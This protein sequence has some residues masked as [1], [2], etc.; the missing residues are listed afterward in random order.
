[1]IRFLIVVSYLIISI[2][3]A[4]Q[5]IQ[6]MDG[7]KWQ[8]DLD[9]LAKELPKRHKNLYHQV[10][11]EKFQRAI[12]NLKQN[13]PTLSNHEIAVEFARIVAM[14]G[15]GHTELSLIQSATQF[16]RIPLYFYYFGDSLYIIAATEIYK[17]TIG[18]R[19]LKI[20]KSSVE[21]SFEAVKALISHD[22][23]MEYRH[24]GPRYLAVPKI[25]HALKL[26]ENM[27]YEN[28]VV[29]ATSG[30]ID[31]IRVKAFE[32]GQTQDWQTALA[33]SGN[34]KPLFLQ[35]QGNNYWFTFLD[36]TKTL[37]LNYNRCQNQN[38][39][40][41]IKEF[42]KE[43]FNFVDNNTIDRFIFDLRDNSGGNMKLNRPLIEG[44]IE[45][46]SINLKGNLF[47]ITGRRT[48]SAGTKA[49]IE[50]K[51]NTEAIFVG[52]PSRGKPNGYGE[53]EKFRLPN[54]NIVVEYSVE[55]YTMIPELGDAN[56]LA[57]DIPVENSYKDYAEGRDKVFEKILSHHEN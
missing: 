30:E 37:Y 47:V 55:F 34:K 41:S 21:E 13:V 23:D 45:R 18:S 53:I 27:E 14:I 32:S 2:G 4:E 33:L 8:E 48:F 36:D 20:G 17:S 7:E 9:Y 3:C 49:A 12:E 26:T 24:S 54:S 28:F 44:I 31:T 56:Y 46:Y 6:D 16:E 25:L 22:N 42:A 52:E 51:K 43:V 5:S 39:K 15:D 40:P 1:M 57:V 19:V 35:N 11:A 38:G 29:E 50:L 10:S